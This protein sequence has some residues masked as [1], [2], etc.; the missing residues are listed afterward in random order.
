MTYDKHGTVEMTQLDFS[1]D[2]PKAKNP[3]KINA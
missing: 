1:A 2:R 3:I